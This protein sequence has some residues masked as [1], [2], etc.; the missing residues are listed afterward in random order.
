MKN[1]NETWENIKTQQFCNRRDGKW[2]YFFPN[3]TFEKLEVY[4][5]GVL[6]GTKG[7]SELV[8][9]MNVKNREDSTQDS[10]IEKKKPFFKRKN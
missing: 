2:T 7:N 1:P 5:N 8:P 6:I 3:G 9:A 4:K 10:E